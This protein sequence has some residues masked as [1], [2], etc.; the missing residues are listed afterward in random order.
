MNADAREVARHKELV[1]LNRASHRLHENDDLRYSRLAT[2]ITL[3]QYAYLVELEGIEELVQLPVLL[4]FLK[5]DVVLLETV[6]GELGLVI[7]EDFE[8]L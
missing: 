2:G 3:T 5:L 4:G 6:Q 7:D 8:W 1:Q